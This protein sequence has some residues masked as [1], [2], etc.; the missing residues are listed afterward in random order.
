MENEDTSRV[1]VLDENGD[2]L[3]F[4]EDGEIIPKPLKEVTLDN[5]FIFWSRDLN[6]L[7]SYFCNLSDWMVKGIL[8]VN[9]YSFLDLYVIDEE[10]GEFLIG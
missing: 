8:N 3:C 9:S 2:I 10:K 5:L 1:V 7:E 6:D 4:S